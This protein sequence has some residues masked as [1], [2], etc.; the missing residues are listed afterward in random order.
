MIAGAVLLVG[1]GPGLPDLLTYQARRALEHAQLILHDGDVPTVL[2]L[3]DTAERRRAGPD[4]AQILADA[5]ARG[6]RAVRVYR[7]DPFLY[8]LGGPLAQAL[9]QLGARFEVVPGLSGLTAATFAG[10]PLPPGRLDAALQSAEPRYAVAAP[11]TPDQLVAAG[12]PEPAFRVGGVRLPW[13]ERRPLFGRTIGVTR[14]PAQQAPLVEALARLGARVL[15][16]PTIDFEAGE[17]LAPY[18]ERLHTYDWVL[19]TS[20]NGVEAFFEA[21]LAM[22]LDA[23]VFGG[24]RIACIGPATACRVGDYGL[25]PDL[26]PPEFV[27]ESLIDALRA[28]GLAGRRF[29]LPRAEVAREILPE[30]LRAE[31]AHVE[32]P[33][34]YRTVTPALAADAVDALCAGAVDLV[35]FTASSTVN[36]LCESVPDAARAHVRAACIGPITRRTA[37]A[38]GLSVA[39][40]A[41]QYTVPGLVAALAGW[42]LAHPLQ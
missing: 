11:G 26:V 2:S 40:E 19:F 20:V 15:P 22:G 25:R 9:E 4:E 18:I 6:V 1:A 42:G 16:M 7:G 12:L 28:Q 14:A 41:A 36:A 23:R 34:A 37:E 8:G 21:V 33:V 35:T 3:A 24:R 13:F 31:G 17:P 29:L 32:V 39:V 5:A 10:I 27:A 30:T 38:Q